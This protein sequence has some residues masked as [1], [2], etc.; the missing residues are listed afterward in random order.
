M[1][2]K[3]SSEDD[4]GRR[5]A[6]KM[7]AAGA[8]LI[9]APIST[10]KAAQPSQLEIP[11]VV[12]R[13]DWIESR[14]VSKDWWHRI[15]QVR[16]ARKK[17]GE[18]HL[19]RPF[20]TEVSIIGNSD[21]EVNGRQTTK[22]KVQAKRNHL[23]RAKSEI[24]DSIEGIGVE[25]Q[26]A[27][28]GEEIPMDACYYTNDSSLSNLI[29]GDAFTADG[30][31]GSLGARAYVDSASGHRMVSAAHLWQDEKGGESCERTSINGEYANMD[32]PDGSGDVKVGEVTTSNPA[33]DYALLKNGAYLQGDLTNKIHHNSRELPISGSATNYEY[34]KSNDTDVWKTG[35]STGTLIGKIKDI[36][37]SFSSTDNC[38]YSGDYGI[39]CTNNGAVGDSGGP[40]Y[41]RT[42][43][44]DK[45]AI[46]TITSKGVKNND[47]WCDAPETVNVSGMQS[48]RYVDYG[49]HF[50]G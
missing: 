33:E 15:K 41:I 37:V 3:S 9:T 50:G 2:E 25:V 31:R 46:V 13:G 28:K 21:E 44:G 39:R 45:A 18:A 26:P 6:I 32:D 11:I 10:A 49:I 27:P 38:E 16:Q 7:T 34:I 17:L 43:N 19:N 5:E 47:T 35:S 40:V 20:V 36:Q 29:G 30:G 48:D 8:G 12:C 1:I 4:I 22:L 23:A 42:N 14:D 24:P